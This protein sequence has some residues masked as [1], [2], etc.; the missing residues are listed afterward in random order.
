MQGDNQAFTIGAIGHRT[1][2][3]SSAAIRERIDQVL[4]EIVEQNT[5][6]RPS[7]ASS[8]AEGADR[9]FLAAAEGM[10]LA[11]DLLIP[12]T[13][14]CFREDFTTDTSQSEFEDLLTKAR[15]VTA[16]EPPMGKEAGYLWASESLLDR[17]D[18]L[19]AVW[20]GGVGHGPAGTAATVARA[21]ERGIPVIWIPSHP[22]YAV[23]RLE[24]AR[25]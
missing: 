1:L 9:L 24:A 25:V 20:D 14:A 23:R 5:A 21:R 11:F 17:S 7:L 13:P 16:P 3:G 8:V 18:V 19:I 15:S 10:G 12:C 4:Q 2:E 22:P 6:C